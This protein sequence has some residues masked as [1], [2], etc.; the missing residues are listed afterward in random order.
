MRGKRG[1]REKQQREKKEE[2]GREKT[3]ERGR[4]KR[5]RGKERDKD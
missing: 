3:E 4:G 2:R 5:W 1:G